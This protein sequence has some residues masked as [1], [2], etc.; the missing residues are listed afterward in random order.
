MTGIAAQPSD[1]TGVPRHGR[2]RRVVPSRRVQDA[3]P[4]DGDDGA[5]ARQLKRR[6]VSS[7]PA[8]TSDSTASAARATRASGSSSGAN[9]DRTK[10]ATSRGSPRPGRPTPTR[11][12]RNSGEPSRPAI[13]R[14]PLWPARPPPRRAW[15]RPDVEIDLV[16]DD[17]Q[18]VDRRPC[19]TRSRRLDR[20]A[21]VVHVRVGLEQRE[22]P[23]VE[24]HLGEPAAE[25]ALERA[26]VTARELVDDHPADV[27]PVTLVLAARVSE[28]DDEQ[29]ERRGRLAPTEERQGLLLVV[30]RRLVRRL[31]AAAADSCGGLGRERLVRGLLG[32]G[33][34]A[35]ARAAR[36][37]RSRAGRRGT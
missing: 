21:R 26:V 14:R 36:D 35:R 7:R 2:A 31:A 13:E 8:P 18:A 23:A 32:L 19:R 5:G 33:E 1:S 25:L 37:A 3:A 22:A 30:G 28:P 10:S 4:A 24:A 11:S 6:C 12:R 15:S 29:V 17:E 20:A 16:V 27:V 34:A 9:G